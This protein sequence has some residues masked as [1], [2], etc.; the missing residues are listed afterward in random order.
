MV[1]ERASGGS[2][3]DAR[4][5]FTSLKQKVAA[6]A[7]ADGSS[8]VDPG[9]TGLPAMAQPAA[10]PMTHAASAAPSNRR[11]KS[12]PI[13]RDRKAMAMPTVSRRSRAVSE[14]PYLSDD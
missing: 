1:L 14:R 12:G 5:R 13:Q 11:P 4:S 6:E 3:A 9:W 10:P 2:P 7:T 8:T